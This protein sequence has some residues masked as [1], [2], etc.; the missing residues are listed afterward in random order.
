MATLAGAVH[1]AEVQE[2]VIVGP[3]AV[4]LVRLGFHALKVVPN[5][6]PNRGLLHTRE[7]LKSLAVTGALT[8]TG[9][10]YQLQSPAP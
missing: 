10:A 7:E 8:P 6:R 3:A 2:E 4:A 1:A 9:T 5:S